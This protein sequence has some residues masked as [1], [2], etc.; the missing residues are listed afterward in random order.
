MDKTGIIVVSIC[1]AL[2]G[3]W[4]FEQTKLV[5]QQEQYAAAQMQAQLSETNSTP[6]AA[7][8]PGFPAA[9]TATMTAAPVAFDTNL[10]EQTIVLTNARARY[11]FTSRGGGLKLVELL[12]YPETISARWKGEVHNSSSVTAILP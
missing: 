10:P 11:T 1:V 7:N 4:F 2:L 5:K 9:N 8:T 6:A 12:R 3:I